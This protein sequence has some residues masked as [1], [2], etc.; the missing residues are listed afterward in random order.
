[1]YRICLN[2]GT[3]SKDQILRAGVILRNIRIPIFMLTIAKFV[4]GNEENIILIQQFKSCKL[5]VMC[6]WLT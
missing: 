3:K 4:L 2:L 5:I 6:L 1:M